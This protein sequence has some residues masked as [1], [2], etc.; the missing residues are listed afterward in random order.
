MMKRMRIALVTGASSGMGRESVLQIADIG[1][2]LDEIWVVARRK[3]RLLELERKSRR[4]LRLLAID[5]TDPDG[6]AQLRELLARLR[7]D[8]K[9][10]VNAAGYGKLAPVGKTAERDELGMIRLNCEA[11]CLVTRLVLPYMSDNSRIIQYASA[12][13]FLPQPGF[14]VYAASKSFVLSYSRALNEELRPRAIAVTAVCPGPVRTEFFDVAD[15]GSPM[16]FW[17][18]PF[19]TSAHRVVKKALRDSMMGRSVSVCGLPMKLFALLCRL[20]PTG[21]LLRGYAGI[22][23]CLPVSRKPADDRKRTGVH[24]SADTHRN[25]GAEGSRP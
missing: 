19:M 10:L 11:L 21:F 12:A 24:P 3:E 9:W 20:L 1:R 2:G 14:A 6:Q 5:L 17:K 7:P 22:S 18:K 25:I 4:P 13:A 15:T 8:V 16:P 23:S